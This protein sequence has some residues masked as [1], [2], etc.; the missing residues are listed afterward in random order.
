MV[1]VLLILVV[2]PLPSQ[3]QRLQ[4]L[5]F[6]FLLR[7]SVGSLKLFAV[8]NVYCK[9]KAIVAGP[10]GCHHQGQDKKKKQVSETTYFLLQHLP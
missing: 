9:V 2:I 6:L 8:G 7:M 4:L 1:S 3:R 10:K 5:N